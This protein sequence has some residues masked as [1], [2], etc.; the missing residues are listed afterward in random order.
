MVFELEIMLKTPIETL[1][2][3]GLTINGRVVPGAAGNTVEASAVVLMR[4]SKELRL[5]AEYEESP[6]SRKIKLAVATPFPS[7]PSAEIRFEGRSSQPGVL[8]IDT[9][10]TVVDR[11][12]KMLI[13]MDNSSP[14]T[15]E[16]DLTLALPSA[17]PMRLFA[18]VG[19]Q[20]PYT[21][22]A[23]ADWGTSSMTIKGSGKI[24]GSDN[25]EITLSCD[26]PSME[27]NGY[28]IQIINRPVDK[29]RRMELVMK[30]QSASV[31]NAKAI[32]DVKESKNGVEIKGNAEVNAA[33]P[34]I[35]VKYAILKSL[36]EKSEESG[37]E[38]KLKLD[39]VSLPESSTLKLSKIESGLKITN[40]EKTVMVSLAN[41]ENVITELTWGLKNKSTAATVSHE[42]VAMLKKKSPSAEI[43]RGLRIKYLSAG[44]KFEHSTD[45]IFDEVKGHV[46]GYKIYRKDGE[47]GLEIST[48]KRVIGVALEKVKGA[49]LFSKHVLSVWLDKANA[50]D[51]RLTISTSMEPHKL[52]DMDGFLTA[53]EIRH[54]SLP[55]DIVYKVDFHTGSRQSLFHIKLDMDVFDAE[56][57]RFILESNIKSTPIDKVNKNVTIETVFHSVGTDLGAMLVLHGSVAESD[58][59]L[60]ANLKMME[61]DSIAKELFINVNSNKETAMLRMGSPSKTIAFEGRFDFDEVVGHRRVLVTA[62]SQILALP[63]MSMIFDVNTMPHVD[64]RVFNK[65]TPENYY[66]I[67]GGLL[68]DSKFEMVM[69]R[70][71]GSTKRDLF[72]AYVT[73][74]TTEL[75]HSR[76][77]WD[78]ES[79]REFLQIAHTR[80]LSVRSEIRSS[81]EVLARELSAIAGKW[82]AFDS[83][84]AD[85]AAFIAEYSQ[86][87]SQLIADIKSDDSFSDAVALVKVVRTYVAMVVENVRVIRIRLAE[88]DLFNKIK[89]LVA[90]KIEKMAEI[91]RELSS[92]VSEIIDRLIHRWESLKSKLS[93][94]RAV[95]QYVKGKKKIII[96]V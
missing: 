95:L 21:I 66:A 35:S 41:K 71:V 14:K 52:Q 11:Q 78:V 10:V 63:V 75:L 33:E 83:F 54:P 5:D 37:V 90:A 61:G 8:E 42:L 23:R 36:I 64:I 79:I 45:L 67:S 68:E 50:A 69:A 57:K 73:L 47:H 56:H 44:V 60:G 58:V 80:V 18:R 6:E 29:R 53:V 19:L 59:A 76:L 70:Q 88:S 94:S 39:I 9:V 81:L 82:R 65:A 13:R 49:K 3:T 16:F 96:S 24:I 25:F 28:E 40:K 38:Y 55:R 62:S 26:S 72:G 92:A 17:N 31:F 15:T 89:A 86:Q 87:M 12:T 84:R 32:Y 27:I 4:E 46:M 1:R 7:L 20:T 51:N 77:T 85:S 74:N 43:A 48:P 2:R 93:D 91:L 34:I 22:E 30:K